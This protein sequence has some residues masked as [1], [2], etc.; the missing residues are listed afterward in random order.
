MLQVAFGLTCKFYMFLKIN[1]P[2]YSPPLLIQKLCTN[3]LQPL[4]LILA[5][6]FFQI[7]VVTHVGQT[8]DQPIVR[9][10]KES[11]CIF[12]LFENKDIFEGQMVLC[13]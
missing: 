4:S 9:P 6:G 7:L 12:M 5:V 1:N 10:N 3:L 13:E 11:A 2:V 8:V